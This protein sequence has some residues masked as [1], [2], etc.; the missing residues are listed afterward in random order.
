[1]AEN[2]VHQSHPRDFFRVE[3]IKLL[4]G[5]PGYLSDP[6]RGTF[7]V[8]HGESQYQRMRPQFMGYGNLGWTPAHNAYYDN[9]AVSIYVETLLDAHD[10]ER[11]P[12]GCITEKTWEPLIKGHF[13]LPFGYTGMIQDL[14]PLYNTHLAPFIDY[15]YDGPRGAVRWATF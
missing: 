12:L 11:D 1:M 13:I 10:I 9:T 5:Y 4:S 15:T 8:G 2:P 7:L 6:G 3:L 14:Q